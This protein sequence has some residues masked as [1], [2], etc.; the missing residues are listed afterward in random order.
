MFCNSFIGGCEKSKIKELFKAVKPKYI[1]YKQEREAII[2]FANPDLKQKFWKL[3]PES[4]FYLPLDEQEV[5][6][7]CS[8]KENSWKIRLIFEDINE[9]T[10]Q[11][12][13]D[14]IK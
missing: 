11:S 9:E 8:E 10:A 5:A 4:W 3:Y 12:I 13:I 2:R 6:P 14:S 7:P 1:D